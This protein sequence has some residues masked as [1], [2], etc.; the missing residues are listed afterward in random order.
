VQN[1]AGDDD[2]E[3][4]MEE[5][6]EDEDA[7]DGAECVPSVSESLELTSAYQLF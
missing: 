7:D 6:E 4:A 3:E 5:D 1:Y 2:D